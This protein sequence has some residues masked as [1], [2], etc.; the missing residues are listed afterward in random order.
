MTEVILVDEQDN[1]IGKE[2]KIKAHREAKLHRA[3]S[4]LVFNEVGEWLLQKRA[5]SKYHSPGLWANTCCSHPRLGKDLMAEAKKR[6]KEEMGFDCP[7]KEIFTFV[8]KAKLGDLTEYEFDHVFLGK[9]SGKPQPNKEEADDWKWISLQDL[10]KDIKRNPD[11]YTP[12]F[13][14]IFKEFRKRNY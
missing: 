1:E 6:L 4:V 11:N 3:F 13:K 12:W 7:L 5:K 14:I 10:K 8:Y 2:E 9:F